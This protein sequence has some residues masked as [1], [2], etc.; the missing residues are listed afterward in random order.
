M[1]SCKVLVPIGAAGAGISLAA[2][3]RGMAMKPDVI[4]ADAGSTDSGPAYLGKGMCKYSQKALEHDLEI[5]VKG[6]REAGIP[7]LIGSCGT[8]GTDNM[9]DEMEQI[10]AAVLAKYGLHAKIAKIYTEQSSDILIEKWEQGKIKALPGAPE[11]TKDTFAECEHI[12]ALAGAEPFIEAY[13]HGADI[14]LCGRSTD[15]AIMAAFPLYKK[16]PEGASWHGA[17]TVECGAQCSDTSGNN[18]IIL[19][20]DDEGFTVTPTMPD[21]HCTPYTV[22]AHLLYENVNPFRLTEPSGSF[23]TENAVYTQQDERTVRVTGS[24]FEKASVYTMKLEGSRI[25][26]YQNISLVGIANREIMENPERWIDN[27]SD[28][29]QSLLDR[30]GF[31]RESYSFNF[32]MYG[33]NAVTDSVMSDEKY[34]PRE[35]GVLLTVTAETQELAT[36]IAKEFNPYL[37][38]FPVELT[39]EKELLPTFAFPFSPVDCPRGAVYEFCLHHIVEVENPLELVT[40]TYQER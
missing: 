15:T 23:L 25:A 7:V 12:V 40:I 36:Q 28:Y 34:V 4:A 38:H 5:M 18:C 2:F 8:C 6:A 22:S 16:M 14:I 35:I 1:N 27:I 30:N 11:I 13:E 19:E 29:V 9:V 31:T 32:K 24:E 3:E 39:S 10:V 20:V 17:K 21:T 26:G 33:Y 37:L